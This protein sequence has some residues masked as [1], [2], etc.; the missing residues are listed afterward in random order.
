MSARRLRQHEADHSAAA[1]I[2]AAV[3]TSAV[4]CVC[5]KAVLWREFVL[6]RALARISEAEIAHRGDGQAPTEGVP[7]VIGQQ[8]RRSP[9]LPRTVWQLL[10]NQLSN[11]AGGS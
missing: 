4:V 7:P 5:I 11:N 2:A 9:G 8:R 6:G 1:S 10:R 3:N